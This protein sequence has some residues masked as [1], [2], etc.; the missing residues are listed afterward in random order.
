MS[1]SSY[2][3]AVRK[4]KAKLSESASTVDSL[5]R[6]SNYG[7]ARYTISNAKAKL[8]QIEREVATR[9][10]PTAKVRLEGDTVVVEGPLKNSIEAILKK[11][12]TVTKG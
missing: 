2:T 6:Q 12:G 3:E 5:T 10:S 8:A 9:F 1:L 7:I 4:A 11:Y